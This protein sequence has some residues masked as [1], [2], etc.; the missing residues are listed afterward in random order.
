MLGPQAHEWLEEN[1]GHSDSI[2]IVA[3]R[4]D[5]DEIASPLTGRLSLPATPDN[6]QYGAPRSLQLSAL[7]G[8]L[9]TIRRMLDAGMTVAHINFSHGDHEGHT[10]TAALLRQ[11]AAQEGKVLAILGDLQGPSCA[12]VT[13]AGGMMLSP[14]DEIVLTPS[15]PAGRDPP[16]ASRPHCRGPAGQSP[17]VIGDGELSLP[18]LKR[19]DTLRVIV[20]VPGCSNR[21][22]G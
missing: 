14:G 6:P 8:H 19:G 10:K 18:W 16:A 4:L 15:R 11:V 12:W 17:E 21:A 20:T 5:N 13:S 7:P 1:F 3:R 2:R 22:R 9:E